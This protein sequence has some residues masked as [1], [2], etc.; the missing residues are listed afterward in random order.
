MSD[1]KNFSTKA[2]HQASN[3]QTNE[4]VKEHVPSSQPNPTPAN[5]PPPSTDQKDKGVQPNQNVPNKK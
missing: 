2:S 5:T 3:V 4:Q 1:F